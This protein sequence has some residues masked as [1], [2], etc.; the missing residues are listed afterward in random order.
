MAPYEFYSQVGD[1][2]KDHEFWG[3]P[4]EMNMERPAY[5]IDKDLPGSDVAA[6]TSA[7]LA[8]ASLVFKIVNKQY[9]EELLRRAKEL[10][11]FSTKYRGFYHDSM[12]DSRNHYE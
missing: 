8:A 3:R 5:K 4:E 11:E 9:S 6:E 2:R 10:F 7:A 1:F 12:K